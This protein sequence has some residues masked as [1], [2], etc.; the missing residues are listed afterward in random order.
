MSDS[1]FIPTERIESKIY[2]VRGRKVMLDRDL[3]HLYGVS[4]KALNQAV[5]R[6]HERFPEDFMFILT[7]EES[8]SLRSQIVTSN[9]GR[10][11]ARYLPQVFTEYGVAMLSSVL[12]SERAILVNIQIIRTFGRLREMLTESDNFRRKLELM[13][14]QY[15]ENFK[16]IFDVIR[17]L[18]EMKEEPREEIGFRTND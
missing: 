7:A 5:R 2:I 15:D 12:N 6:N 18:L 3:A 9:V 11:G 14:K 4:T 10:G 16:I 8:K 1:S 13:E 17:A